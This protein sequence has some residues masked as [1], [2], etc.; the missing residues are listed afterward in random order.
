MRDVGSAANNS[1]DSLFASDGKGPYASCGMADTA[2]EKNNVSCPLNELNGSLDP[3]FYKPAEKFTSTPIKP[4]KNYFDILADIMFSTAHAGMLSAMGV[5]KDA[6]ITFIK[7]QAPIFADALD[8]QLSAPVWRSIAW[9]ALADL[10]LSTLDSTDKMLGLINADLQQI[11]QIIDSLSAQLAAGAAGRAIYDTSKNFEVAG[12][13]FAALPCIIGDKT[14]NCKSLSEALKN[15]PGFLQLPLEVQ[16]LALKATSAGNGIAGATSF[17]IGALANIGSL[18]K[19]A[20]AIRA[21]LYK[22][23]QN[24]QKIL[25]RDGLKIDMNKEASKF[26]ATLT[27]ITKTGLK[28]SNMSASQMHALMGGGDSSLSKLSGKTD[29]NNSGKSKGNSNDRAVSGSK[30]SG[31]SGSSGDGQNSGAQDGKG[32]DGLTDAE[33]AAKLAAEAQAQALAQA[34][35]KKASGTMGSA[36]QGDTVHDDN[37]Y[38]LFEVITNRYQ[39][40][41]YPRL[42]KKINE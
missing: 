13:T 18:N 10:V 35:A 21:D 32:A 42:F 36:N 39:K 16:A 34:Q 2:Y 15:S 24:L 19:A 33:R 9:K 27:G 29:L 1:C 22:R 25:S 23:Q 40:S 4:R 14:G 8:T 12:H 37:G 30:N 28:A 31:A 11:Q 20:G 38:T 3:N 6:V 17:T 7:N 26:A 41:A 5:S